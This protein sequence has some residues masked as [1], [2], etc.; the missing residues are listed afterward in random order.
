MN[1]FIKIIK[2]GVAVASTLLGRVVTFIIIAKSLGPV[3]FGIFAFAY[4]FC[5]LFGI[6]LDYGYT[7]SILKD[8]VV[9]FN[10][11]GGV[12]FSII[13]TKFFLFLVLSVILIF[14]Q[15][16]FNFFANSSVVIIIWLSITIT[17]FANVLSTSLR[18]HGK[19]GAESIASLLSNS[20]GLVYCLVI[21][22]VGLEYVTYFSSTFLIIS[23]LYSFSVTYIYFKLYGFGFLYFRFGILELKNEIKSNILYSLNTLLQRGLAFLDVLILGVFVN[24][25]SLGIYQAGQKIMQGLFPGALVL[26]NVFLPLLSNRDGKRWRKLA[27]IVML[28]SFLSGIT[29]SGTLILTAAPMV[30]IIF[31][32]EYVQLVSYIKFFA[33]VIA[34]RYV[35]SGLAILIISVG[36]HS[37]R[38][39]CNLISTTFFLVLAPILTYYFDVIGMMY[40]LVVNAILTLILYSLVIFKSQKV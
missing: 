1:Y 13:Q 14:L 39:Y 8:G 18:S 32:D 33:I 34:V 6:V 38:F 24:P 12:P 29:L 31:S 3:E 22:E 5:S 37:Y 36:R 30:K 2:S 40:A 25:I 7:E 23:V 17:S 26:N 15:L 27:L 11:S 4:A 16:Y 10:R 19:H 20:A 21:E 9:K 28:V 35:A